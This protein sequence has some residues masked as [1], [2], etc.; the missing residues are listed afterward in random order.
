MHASATRKWRKG[1]RF[2]TARSGHTRYDVYGNLVS[3]ALPTGTVVEYLS[4][5]NNRRVQRKIDGVVTASWIYRDRLRPLAELDAAGNV[6]ARFVYASQRNVPDYMIKGGTTYRLVT[7]QVGSVRL[8]VDAGTGNVVQRIDYDPWG[9]VVSD[10][11]P[12][13]QPFGFAGGLHDPETGLVRFG[14][15]DYDAVVGR[16]TSKDSLLFE[17]GDSNLFGY[18]IG[19]PVNHVDPSGRWYVPPPPPGTVA[20]P[21]AF[22]AVIAFDIGYIIGESIAP[23]LLDDIIDSIHDDGGDDECDDDDGGGGGGNDCSERRVAC[24][25]CCGDTFAVGPGG[26]FDVCF[27]GCQAAWAICLALEMGGDPHPA[28]IGFTCWK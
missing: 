9:V 22:F 26:P 16:W 20:V 7:D 28:I 6:V 15:R 19:D 17:G 2:G 25:A 18:V 23:W 14:A 5:G 24:T 21:G 13:F 12:G 8:V 10:T 1:L 3:V 27:D 4:D 11:N